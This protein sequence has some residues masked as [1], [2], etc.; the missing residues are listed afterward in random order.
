MTNQNERPY[1]N[2][3]A[4]DEAWHQRKR[5]DLA[6]SKIEEILK[7]IIPNDIRPQHSPS[8]LSSVLAQVKQTRSQLE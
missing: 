3:I 2:G 5:A 7:I 4:W 1:P 6:E 8:S